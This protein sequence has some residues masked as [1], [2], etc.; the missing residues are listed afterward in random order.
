MTASLIFENYWT[1]TCYEYEGGPVRWRTR[2]PNLIPNEGLNNALTQIYKTPA[3][4]SWFVGLVDNAGFTAFA[5][6]DTA[7]QIGGS[8]G[9][10]ECVAYT[11]AVRQALT[12]GAVA[13]QSVDNSASLATFT[14]NATKTLK[15]GFIATSSVKGGT[16]GTLGGE[17]AFIEG[18]QSVVSGNIITVKITLTAASA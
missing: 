15:G 8:N 17:A 10:A 13:A 14:I 9:W 3:A 16:A 2:V 7:A 6:A 11:E 18:P 1:V 12:L 5:A 4:L